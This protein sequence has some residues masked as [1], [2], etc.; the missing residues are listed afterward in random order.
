MIQE[1][2]LSAWLIILLLAG[3]LGCQA[4]LD[5][6][7]TG[8]WVGQGTYVDYE[9]SGNK[10]APA[11]TEQRARDLVYPTSLTIT[12]ENI[13]GREA[14]VFEIRSQRGKL[15]NNTDT[16]TH[17]LMAL[18]KLETLENGSTLYALADWK[19]KPSE[20]NKWD[21]NNFNTLGKIASASCIRSPRGLFL[22]L[23]YMFPG[24]GSDIGF[25]DTFQFEAGR[26]LK[27]GS[28]VETKKLKSEQVGAAE[29]EQLMMVNWVED[30]RKQ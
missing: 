23:Y 3:S 30:L 21:E 1:K 24:A 6:I 29:K 8:R 10:G 26:L 4:G 19:Y 15:M 25:T 16:E 22:Q 11:P 27:T 7:P 5:N 13:F 14:Y 18:V 9:A 12:K 2:R 28:I 20:N 17:I